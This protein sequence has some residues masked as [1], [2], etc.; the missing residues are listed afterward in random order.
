MQC[1]MRFGL[2]ATFLV[3]PGVSHA[4]TAPQQIAQIDSRGT[5]E[6]QRACSGDARRHC[7]SV[8]DQGDAVVLRCLQ[9]HRAKLT[10][11]CLAVLQKYGH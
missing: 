6:D 7:R 11:G 8:L 9:Q 1:M 10:R 2:I 3:L 4:Q 5:P